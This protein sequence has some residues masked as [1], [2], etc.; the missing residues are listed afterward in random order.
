MW[1]SRSAAGILEQPPR[2]VGLLGL[3]ASALLVIC[4]ASP[5]AAAGACTTA[6]TGGGDWPSYGHDAA[7]TRTQPEASGL[8]PAAV[9]GLRPLWAFSTSSAGD[10]TGFNST[11]VVY[12]GCVFV[13]SSGGVAYALDAKTGRVVWQRK[14]EA[15]SPGSGGVVVGASAI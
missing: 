13:G 9:A 8:G 5:A 12:Q 4:L 15:P 6:P 14:L 1:G 11:P 3:V 2:R 7:N 10:D